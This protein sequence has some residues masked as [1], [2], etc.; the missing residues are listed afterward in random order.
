MK[1][2]VAL[3]VLLFAVSAASFCA[4]SSLANWRQAADVST[5]AAGGQLDSECG[6]A[7]S[8]TEELLRY[9]GWG[10]LALGLVVLFVMLYWTG[11]DSEAWPQSNRFLGDVS[12]ELASRPR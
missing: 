2:V 7:P 9:S 4:T 3:L 8:M 1:Q 12:H 11:S 5:V 6:T 10:F